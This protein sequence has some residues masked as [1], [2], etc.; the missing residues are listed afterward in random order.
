[1][2]Y[3]AFF[4]CNDWIIIIYICINELYGISWTNKTNQ[5]TVESAGNT[6]QVILEKL[7]LEAVANFILQQ[8]YT[9]LFFEI[10]G[11]LMAK[12]YHI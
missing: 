5:R 1:M 11:K 7:K 9:F 12:N 2:L 8:L 10:N 3:I 6:P 4:E